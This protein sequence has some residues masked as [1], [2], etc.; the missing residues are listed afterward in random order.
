[1]PRK[2]ASP[3]PGKCAYCAAPFESARVKRFCS[4]KHRRA[5]ASLNEK[6]GAIVMPY[7]MAWITGK[8]GGNTPPHP[9]AGWAMKELTGIVRG[10][11]DEDRGEGRPPATDY[12]ESLKA[13]GF[14]YFDR[15]A[16]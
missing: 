15:K 8:G 5:F 2:K 11:I 16:S 14:L 4:E 13:S 1:M 10:F 12:A 6:R 9:V 3:T 7:L